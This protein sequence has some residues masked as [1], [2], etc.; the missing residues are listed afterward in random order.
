MQLILGPWTHGG[1]NQTKTQDIDFGPAAR[2]DLQ[3]TNLRWFDRHL[4]GPA[5]EAHES[6]V[7]YFVLGANTWRDAESWPPQE[8]KPTPLYL[9]AKGIADFFAP[10]TNERFS[11]FDS[12]PAK[13]V[14]A[15][16]ANRSNVS[17]AALWS[18]MD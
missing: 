10:G 9:R 3:A 7:R 2:I 17:R 15:V 11:E 13:P 1:T 14:P 5:P 4:K 18:P 8:A 16:P 12:D 6:A